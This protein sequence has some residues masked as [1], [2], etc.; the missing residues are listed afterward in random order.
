ML[1]RRVQGT[2]FRSLSKDPVEATAGP[3]RT[4]FATEL[5]GRR[6]A[7]GGHFVAGAQPVRSTAAPTMVSVSMPEVFVEVLDVAGLT[8]VLDAEACGR[9]AVDAREKGE[10]VRM[11]VQYRQDRGS[12][13]G[14]EERVKDA[15]V[16]GREAWRACWARKTRSG[17]VRQTTSVSM[18]ASAS[19]VRCLQD[20]DDHC[21]HPDERQRRAP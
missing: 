17:E 10:R 9:G 13:A 5:F 12:A 8:E 14:R 16:A 19:F 1:S 4:E 21:T 2:T 11:A 3:K 18:P 7:A 6:S 20:F 15:V